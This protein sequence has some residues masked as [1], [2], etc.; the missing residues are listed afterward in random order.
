MPKSFRFQLKLTENTNDVKCS[1]F[2]AAG[3]YECFVS[4]LY[5]AALLYFHNAHCQNAIVDTK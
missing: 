1:N 5:V 4:L 3:M 2:A